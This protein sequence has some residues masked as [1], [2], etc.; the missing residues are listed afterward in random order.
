VG[1][2]IKSA[3]LNGDCPKAKAIAAA[4]RQMDVASGVI[5]NALG[6]CK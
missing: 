2:P 1:G 6:P 4:A 5:D 3:A